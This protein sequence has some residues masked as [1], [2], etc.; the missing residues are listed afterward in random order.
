MKKFLNSKVSKYFFYM[1]L[2]VG[3]YRCVPNKESI[4]NYKGSIVYGMKKYVSG[5]CYIDL[6]KDSLLLN[7]RVH[8]YEYKL[9]Q[10][11]DT[12]K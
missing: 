8:N 4:V 11:G 9:L 6:R 1:L 5:D 3:F 12:I 10:V 7:I 2:V